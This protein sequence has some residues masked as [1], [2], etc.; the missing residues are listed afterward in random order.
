MECQYTLMGYGITQNSLPIDA[1]GKLKKERPLEYIEKRR[2]IET[3]RAQDDEERRATF[4]EEVMS[5]A[6]NTSNNDIDPDSNVY[7]APEPN[8]ILLGR[9]RP[10]QEYSGNLM[11]ADLIDKERPR[12]QGSNRS[13]K[14]KIS[15]EVLRIIKEELHGKFLKKDE[16]TG[17]WIEQSDEVA[18]EKISHSFRTWTA[19]MKKERDDHLKGKNTTNTTTEGGNN[20]PYSSDE[21]QGSRVSGGSSG[22]RR[23]SLTETYYGSGENQNEFDYESSKRIK[24]DTT[25]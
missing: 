14:T 15:R 8:D 2:R 1:D 20:N 21:D 3:Q 12:Y 4:M 5:A 9:G 25:H 24:M 16:T 7:E 23:V 11:L 6:G 19:K 22:G 17:L 13:G 18:R 10:Y